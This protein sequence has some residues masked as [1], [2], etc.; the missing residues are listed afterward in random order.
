MASGIALAS[1]HLVRYSVAT[2]MYIFPRTVFGK[3]PTMSIPRRS[4]GYPTLIGW[5]G[6]IRLFFPLASDI[7]RKFVHIFERRRTFVASSIGFLLFYRFRRE[8]SAQREDP[9]VYDV[10]CLQLRSPLRLLLAGRGYPC[11]S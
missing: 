4:K 1:G 8:R 11:F 3:G 10:G 5:R 2:T 7:R 6:S 9:N